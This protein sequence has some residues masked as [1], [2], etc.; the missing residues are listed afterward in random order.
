MKTV[1]NKTIVGVPFY[2]QEGLEVLEACIGNIDTC[3]N[4]LG[5][6]AKIIIGINGPRV[7]M[8]LQPLAWEI[9][10]SK[11]NADV[12][13]IKTRPGIV[14]TEKAIC[15]KAQEEGFKRIFLTDADISRLPNSLNHMWNQGDCPVVGAN[16]CAYPPEILIQA[17]VKLTKEQIALMSIFEADKHPQAKEFTWPYRPEKRLKGSLLLV[18]TDIAS[19]MFGCQGITSDSIMNSNVPMDQRQII[20][21]ASFMHYARISIIDHVQARVRHFRAAD[22]DN[23]L[24]SFYKKSIIYSPEKA[25]EIA[26]KMVEKDPMAKL[27]ASNFLLQCALR[28]QVADICK[29][30]VLKKN[31]TQPPERVTNTVDFTT[32]VSCFSEAM[33]IIASKLSLIDWNCLNTPEA[34]GKGTT[35]NNLPRVPIN[36][37]PFLAISEYRTLIAS[38]LGLPLIFNP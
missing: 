32:L 31:C 5:L 29:N 9:D 35:Q 8:G 34:N 18:E 6:D 33:T 36:L 1:E 15:A 16:Y 7:S 26:K 11:Y 14:A 19:T 23:Q 17:G 22:A 20:S 38:H 21:D 3:L 2:D 12:E 37:E 24:E 30:V 13:F 4:N 28:H 10:L 27:T 25:D